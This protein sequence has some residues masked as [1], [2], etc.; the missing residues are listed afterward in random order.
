MIISTKGLGFFFLALGGFHFISTH[1]VPRDDPM[2]KT[3]GRIGESFF[4]GLVIRAVPS[5]EK[6]NPHSLLKDDVRKNAC[7]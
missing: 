6:G 4:F 3:M 7:L 1:M 5:L 2:A